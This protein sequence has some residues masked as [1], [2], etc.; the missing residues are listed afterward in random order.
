[1]WLSVLAVSGGAVVGA[2]LRWVLGLWL[3]STYHA[4][5]YG[6]LIAN[7]SGG[8]LIG[9]LIGFFTHGSSLSPEWRLFAITGLC[10]ALTTFSTFS[11]EMFSALQEGK[12]AMAVIGILAHVIGSLMMTAVGIYSFGLLRG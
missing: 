2:N 1:M 3:N 12:F 9:F 7:L 4:V 10:G 5:P 8:W 11:L 6:T